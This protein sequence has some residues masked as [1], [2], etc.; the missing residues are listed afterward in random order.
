M[1]FFISLVSLS[2]FVIASARVAPCPLLLGEGAAAAAGV[3]GT[4]TEKNRG[5][6]NGN[7]LQMYVF[8]GCKGYL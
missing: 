5:W 4:P 7:A 3:E 6:M 1:K 8:T 2:M